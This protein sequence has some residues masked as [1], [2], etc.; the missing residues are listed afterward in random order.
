MQEALRKLSY[1]GF[2]N[3][4]VLNGSESMTY[5][6]HATIFAHIYIVNHFLALVKKGRRHGNPTTGF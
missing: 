3:V 1:G 4:M 5:S 2:F 6:K